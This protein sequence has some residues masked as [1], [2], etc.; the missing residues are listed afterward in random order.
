MRRTNEAP[1][2]D[3]ERMRE[4]AW[5]LKRAASSF[6]AMTDVYT[7]AQA[8]AALASLEAAGVVMNV[9]GHLRPDRWLAVLFTAVSAGERMQH[10]Y[11]ALSTAPIT[12]DVVD[13]VHA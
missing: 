3:V 8:A 11:V 6:A 12:R 10:G 4:F 2:A 9:D 1:T 5:T 7:E 13:V